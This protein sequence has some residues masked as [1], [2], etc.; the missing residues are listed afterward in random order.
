MIQKIPNIQVFICIKSPSQDLLGG[1]DRRFCCEIDQEACL[2]TLLQTRGAGVD[3]IWSSSE[4]R[5][6]GWGA[7]NRPPKKIYVLI[8]PPKNT[9]TKKYYKLLMR[10]CNSQKGRWEG[11]GRKKTE[12]KTCLQNK[13]TWQK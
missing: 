13:W 5:W 11:F 10:G 2:L 8:R 6:R 12:N 4:P 3:V 7:P 9:Y 1:T